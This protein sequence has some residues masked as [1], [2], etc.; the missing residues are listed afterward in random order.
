MKRFLTIVSF[1]PLSALAQGLPSVTCTASKSPLFRSNETLELT[2]KGEFPV[3]SDQAPAEIKY[4]DPETGIE[5][6]IAMSVAGRGKSRRW[7]CVFPPIRIS[8]GADKKVL[9]DNTIFDRTKGQDMKLTTHCRYSEGDIASNR[10]VNEVI[11]KEYMIY[12]IIKS[13]GLPV[14]DV[15][16]AKIQY[17]DNDNKTKVQGMGFF[18]ESNAQLGDRCGLTHAKRDEVAEAVG[19]KMNKQLHVPYLFSRL[20]SDAR[21][22]VLDYIGGHNSEPFY[23]SLK[24]TRVVVPYDFNDSGQVS[25]GIVPHWT[26]S[27]HWDFWFDR[28]RRG[29][30]ER[31]GYL[32]SISEE[33]KQAWTTNVIAQARQ[34]IAKQEEVLTM[35]QQSPLQPASKDQF[36]KHVQMLIREFQ[37]IVDDRATTPAEIPQ[38]PPGVG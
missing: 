11:I 12:K 15:R 37:R 2:V 27:P 17:V 30:F 10:E 28:L 6:S 38:H 19:E 8:W 29:P 31:G 35:I 36:T 25:S 1:L 14:F 16:L 7:G 18:M 23:D 22:F 4:L 24:V 3:G 5:K 9:R 34:L 26:F 21:D 32:L 13:F 20:I 33:E